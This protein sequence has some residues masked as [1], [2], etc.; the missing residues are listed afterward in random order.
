MALPR[1]GPFK[2]HTTISACSHSSIIWSLPHSKE[3]NTVDFDADIVY[4]EQGQFSQDSPRPLWQR[5]NALR[6]T[7][8]KFDQKGNELAAASSN[9]HHIYTPHGR[10]PTP[11]G[12]SSALPLIWLDASFRLSSLHTALSPSDQRRKTQVNSLGLIFGVI[13][14]SSSFICLSISAR[15][16][17]T[18]SSVIAPKR[19]IP[20]RPFWPSS[21]CTGRLK[22]WKFGRFIVVYESGLW[23]WYGRVFYW[24]LSTIRTN[25]ASS[26]PQPTNNDDVTSLVAQL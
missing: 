4:T 24:H 1:H 22:V 10:N 5:Q 8:D 14:R 16:D 17:N 26:L 20:Q 18:T 6:H 12:C 3:T 9:H 15:R 13:A 7:T 11:S 19:S 2:S 25:R 21:L 23:C